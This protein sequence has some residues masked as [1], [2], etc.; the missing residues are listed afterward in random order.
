VAPAIVT[1][2]PSQTVFAGATVNFT[3]SASGTP[4]LSYQWQKNTV[5]IAGA[6]SASLTLASVTAADAGSYRAV[7]TNTAGTATSAAATLVVN[8]A[9]VAP[10]ITLQPIS[11]GV[12]AGAN[13]SFVIAASGTTPLSYQWRK[14]AAAI[15]GATSATL[16]LPSV[17]TA[18]AGTYSA[19]V[20]NA[21]GS[22]AS[23]NATL[24]VT[25]TVVIVSI[26]SPNNGA[27]FTA[28]ATYP[29]MASATPAAIITRVEFYQGTTLLGSLSSGPYTF[30]VLNQ[31]AGNYS[32]TARAVSSSGA[33]TSA[34]VNVTVTA[35]PPPTGPATVTIS[36]TDPNASEAGPDT[37][38]FQVARTEPTTN[39]LTVHFLIG[40]T[41]V[42]GQ[43]YQ[44][45]TN[46][47][48]IAANSATANIRI[49]PILDAETPTELSDTVI[50]QLDTPPVG[51][52]TYTIGSPSNAVVTIA[53]VIANATNL[54]PLV[55]IIAP[56]DRATFRASSDILLAATASDSDGSVTHVEF[57]AGTT[58]LGPGI[59]MTGRGDDGASDEDREH[60]GGG[61]VYALNWRRVP[62][63]QY[64]I[65]AVATDNAGATTI[66]APVKINV[67]TRHSEGS[68][69][70]S[71][72]GDD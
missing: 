72:G 6:T 9:P 16:N 12:N 68:F 22:A 41:A 11:Q 69:G 7:V 10:A 35:P 26:A 55:R 2:P 61:T 45:I 70:G 15:P 44:L 25:Q 32:Y 13:V 18:D 67:R 56:R 42:N 29:L 47:V 60:R 46:E 71:R 57:Y 4:P 50:L 37:G 59:P 40:G 52:P 23:D 58:D 20:T 49:T 51:Q 28:P 31:G 1:P 3:V 14:N 27:T 65:T 54:P 63:G 33:V 19:I 34:P 48:T 64:S 8:A 38:T 21:A 39:E 5:N 17:T 30:N 43:D 62:V 53:E 36:A 24:T 66:S